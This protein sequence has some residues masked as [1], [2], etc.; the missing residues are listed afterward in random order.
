MNRN[1]Q[2]IHLWVGILNLWPKY[3][4]FCSKDWVQGSIN[5][6]FGLLCPYSQALH[7]SHT[8]TNSFWHLWRYSWCKLIVYMQMRVES[9]IRW[10]FQ[11]LFLWWFLSSMLIFSFCVTWKKANRMGLEWKKK[12]I[13]LDEVP[14]TAASSGC[15]FKH[16]QHYIF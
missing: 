7:C 12:S 5:V 9:C 14:G 10:H 2:I 8:A 4:V 11:R 15:L 3:L 16:I 13:F 6:T 1:D